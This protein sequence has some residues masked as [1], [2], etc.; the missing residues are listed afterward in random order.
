MEAQRVYCWIAHRHRRVVDLL[1]VEHWFVALTQ[2]P[3]GEIY[4]ITESERWHE[5]R[6]FLSRRDRFAKTILERVA[7]TLEERGW[8]Y[9]GNGKQWYCR[10]FAHR[11]I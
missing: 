5:P 9:S 6:R 4:P 1:L 8:E 2:G 7:A 3:A 10:I 11:P